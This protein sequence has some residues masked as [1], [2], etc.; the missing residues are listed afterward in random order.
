MLGDGR[1]EI[2]S[3]QD[4]ARRVALVYVH[5]DRATFERVRPLLRIAFVSESAL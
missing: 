1:I 2:F 5:G 4:R 3:P